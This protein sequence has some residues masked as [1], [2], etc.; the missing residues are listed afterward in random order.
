MSLRHRVANAERFVGDQ[1]FDDG[2]ITIA[3]L[4]SGSLD[5]AARRKLG[6]ARLREAVTSFHEAMTKLLADDRPDEVIDGDMPD[7]TP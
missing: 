4:A 1:D 7:A 6:K 2:P 5:I 3:E